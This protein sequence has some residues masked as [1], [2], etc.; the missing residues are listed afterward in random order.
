VFVINREECCCRCSL[1]L[2]A[3][4]RHSRA[5]AALEKL[6]KAAEALKLYPTPTIVTDSN[7]T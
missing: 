3:D 2:A 4:G 1:L 6:V 7:M 5:M